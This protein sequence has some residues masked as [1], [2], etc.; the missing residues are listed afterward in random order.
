MLLRL[1]EGDLQGYVS[2]LLLYLN[3]SKLQTLSANLL[4]N[5]QVSGRLNFHHCFQPRWLDFRI[6]RLMYY[7]PRVAHDV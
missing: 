4:L 1:N 3:Y 5:I 7:V 6:R 2:Y